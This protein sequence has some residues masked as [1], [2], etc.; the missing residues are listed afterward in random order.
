MSEFFSSAPECFLQTGQKIPKQ[1][2][3][4]KHPTAELVSPKGL[5]AWKQ[6]HGPS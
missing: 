3:N 4:R 1:Q 2:R 6:F 5:I